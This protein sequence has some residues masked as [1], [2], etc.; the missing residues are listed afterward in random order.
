MSAI[1]SGAAANAAAGPLDGLK[2]LGRT[3]VEILHTRL[4]LLSIEIEE[5]QGR[6]AELLLY[7]AL[8]LL[9]LLLALMVAAVFIVAVWWDTPYR[10]V[11]IG[12]A[13]ALTAGAGGACVVTVLRKIQSKPRV[14]AA[15][16]STLAIDIER[17]K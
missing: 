14:F 6:L 7:S 12:S 5:E 8:A 3:V 16:L 13:F 2:A 9:F 15:S 17:L 11:A 10:L 4:E 1:D